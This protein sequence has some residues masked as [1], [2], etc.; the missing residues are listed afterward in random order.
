MELAATRPVFVLGRSCSTEIC[1]DATKN[2]RR[3]LCLC[4]RIFDRVHLHGRV[5][6]EI[7]SIDPHQVLSMPIM[8]PASRTGLARVL[9]AH[10][11]G[12]PLR[13]SRHCH[14]D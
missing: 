2:L 1:K 8:G 7:R 10:L 4:G 14:R 12:L 5:G 6:F 3:R 11:P 9:A 13:H